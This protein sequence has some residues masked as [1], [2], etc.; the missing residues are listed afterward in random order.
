MARGLRPRGVDDSKV[1]SDR[2]WCEV[3]HAELF[4]DD[5]TGVV[6]T[7]P[8]VATTIA[9]TPL[10]CG[11][12]SGATMVAAEGSASTD[13]IIT[14]V[15]SGR[16]RVGFSLG[17]V[18]A[19]GSG[20]AV[21][22]E[23]YLNNAVLDATTLGAILAKITQ[24]TTALAIVHLSAEGFVDMVPGDTIRFKAT[25]STGNFAVKRG[26]LWV[27]QTDDGVPASAV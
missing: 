20:V 23:A 14:V 8:T 24:P 2:L 16:Y 27:T 18:V 4:V 26:R 15:R 13:G 19:A 25:A 11:K 9:A 1:N 22:V 17:E 5:A 21:T 7:T 3:N 12:S 6:L 10:K